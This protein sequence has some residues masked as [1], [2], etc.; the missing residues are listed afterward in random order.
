MIRSHG[1]A[2]AAPRAHSFQRGGNGIG[3][4][5]LLA[6]LITA[7]VVFV[8]KLLYANRL[9]YAQMAF[10]LYYF[11]WKK[12]AN[13]LD[14]WRAI[15][16]CNY[17]PAFVAAFWPL[18]RLPQPEAYWIWQAIEIVAF[19][20]AVW[21]MIRES[22]RLSLGRLTIALGS[23]GLLL[24]YFL[25]S[26]IY[27]AEPSALI[28]LMLL[29]AW[30]F[31]RRGRPGFGGLMLAAATVLKVYPVVIGG[32]FLLRRRYKTV[33]A[34]AAWTI[35]MVIITDPR[36][37]IDSLQNG[38]GA[39]FKSPGWAADGRAISIVFN[40]YAALRD[41]APDGRVPNVPLLVISATLGVAAL[42]AAAI[43]TWQGADTPEIQGITLGMWAALML[44]LCPLTWNHEITLLMPV[45]LFLLLYWLRI[46]VSSSRPLR[47]GTLLIVGAL[48]IHV[49]AYYS[50][51]MRN[52][53]IDFVAVL[54]AFS[55]ACLIVKP[56]SIVVPE[57][58]RSSQ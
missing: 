42:A 1:L 44:L 6:L 2:T 56:R 18:A 33:A 19:F 45:Y 5:F 40:V 14:P 39:Y 11:W 53:H 3:A 49:L 7:I 43:V 25:G 30:S 54:A 8:G 32:Y 28:M 36:R 9:R 21:L 31:S 46:D 41:L 55:G 58:N 24:P 26:T 22:G 10:S 37:W 12:F 57:P 16:P 51:P 52:R 4:K 29:G 35:F 34:G 13:G 17:P 50:T 27:E 38:A 47:P 15:P 20:A 23:V 48:A